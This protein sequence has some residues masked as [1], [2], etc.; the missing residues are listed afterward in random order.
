MTMWPNDPVTPAADNSL[1][2]L[3]GDPGEDIYESIRSTGDED[4]KK[5]VDEWLASHRA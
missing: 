4:F 5:Q 1:F 3:W 2:D